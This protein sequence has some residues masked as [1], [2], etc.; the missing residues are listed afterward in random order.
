VWNT[1]NRS[2]RVQVGK[3]LESFLPSSYERPVFRYQ[4]QFVLEIEYSAGA[5]GLKTQLDLRLAL[6]FGHRLVQ[7]IGPS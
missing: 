6:A 3:C 2:V 4:F 1:D 7:R 5:Q